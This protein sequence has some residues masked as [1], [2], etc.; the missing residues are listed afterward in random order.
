MCTI[1]A[2]CNILL[3]LRRSPITI[4]ATVVQ[5]ISYPMGI[6]WA[7]LM[8]EIT[9]KILG[10]EFELNPGPFNKKE[11][12]IIT[13]MT[14]AGA[15]TSYAIDIFLA[16]EVFY[17]Q[18]F[19]WGFQILTIL[20]TQAMGFGLAGVMR[21]YLVW[22]AAMVWPATLITCTI[23]H[24]LHD[25][26]PSDPAR[27]N[28]WR[29]GRYKFFLLVALITYFYE[30]IPQVIAQFLQIFTFVCWI[31]PNNVIV[32]QVFGGQTGL[33]I[34][35]ISFD[36]SVISGF[37][38]SPLQTPAFAV[39][40][41]AA[42]LIF[43]LIGCIGLTYAG[44]EMYQYL[45]IAANRNFDNVGM[46][47][48][49]SRILTPDLLFNQTA[50][51]EYSP[52][53]LGSAFSFTYGLSF[54]TL[55]STVTHVAFFYG[56]QIVARTRTV[57]YEEPDVHL[58]LMRKYREAPEW[59]FLATFAG[60]F[61]CGM[62]A[63]Q[64]WQTFLPWWAYILAIVIGVVFILPVGI[65]QAITN[66]QTGLNVITE[67]IVGFMIPGRPIAMMLFKSWGYMTCYNGLAYVSDMKVGHYMKIPPR[68]MFMAQFF[69]V[70]W[71]SFV[72]ISSYNF[73]RGNIEGICT[74]EQPQGLTCPLATT[75]YNASVIWGVIGPAKLFG[76]GQL[77][78]WNNWFWLIGAVLPVGQYFLARKYPRSIL[79]YI[80]FPAIFGAAGMIP[81]ATTW[82]LGQWVLVGLIFNWWIRKRWFG[83]WC[84]L[85]RPSPGSLS[86]LDADILLP[87]RQVATTT[88]CPVL[89]T[90]AQPCASSVSVSAWV[91]R[92]RSSPSGGATRCRSRTSMP[93]S[94]LS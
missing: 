44:P 62:I 67:L 57:T 53:M 54:A 69:A 36:W 84:K 80:F 45:P 91:C 70:V 60:S 55:I 1:V 46:K 13:I 12:T 77:Y 86:D 79:R 31:A 34:L 8:P 82:Y 83:W 7:K 58:K 14:A 17:G 71:L 5:L 29:I 64:V 26:A 40:N 59:W 25:H 65:I 23:I 47:Y 3:G 6:W 15:T 11:H 20:S 50:Y 72:Q 35:P 10:R 87:P 41:V 42:G 56:P 4:T 75:F 37:L 89:S 32:N 48:N 22:P 92:R 30:W 33:G 61:T 94:P 19:S 28:G 21:R 2:A 68:S 90:S 52:L 66:Q 38:L 24:S 81:P 85:T 43:M 49:T 74:P 73:I 93:T 78:A 9:F 88:F 51:E 16:Q 18:F 63:A 39:M 76:V 27:T